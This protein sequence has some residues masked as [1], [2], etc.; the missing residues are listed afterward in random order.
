VAV[1]LKD[2]DEQGAPPLEKPA[3]TREKLALLI[4]SAWQGLAKQHN[5]KMHRLFIAPFMS[6]SSLCDYYGISLTNFFTA[7]FNV[8]LPAKSFLS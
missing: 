8:A 4:T 7:F 3:A 1:I 5:S 6:T 2:A